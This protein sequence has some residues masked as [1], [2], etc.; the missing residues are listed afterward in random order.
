MVPKEVPPKMIFFPL[1]PPE[2]PMCNKCI[3]PIPPCNP[4]PSKCKRSNTRK[5]FVEISLKWYLVQDEGDWC[6]GLGSS[7]AASWGGEFAVFVL[8]DAVTTD[9]LNIEV[10]GPVVELVRADGQP[11]HAFVLSGTEDHWWPVT[12]TLSR[13]PPSTTI[14][15]TNTSIVDVVLGGGGQSPPCVWDGRVRDSQGLDGTG[16]ASQRN[17]HILRSCILMLE[18]GTGY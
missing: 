6:T 18:F 12:N 17:D 14:L 13:L 7:G 10:E 11:H 16:S 4:A 3:S 5:T 9:D 1:P 2:S 8:A 15:D